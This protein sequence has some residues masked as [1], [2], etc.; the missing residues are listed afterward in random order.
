MSHAP[1]TTVRITDIYSNAEIMDE[2]EMLFT[3]LDGRGWEGHDFVVRTVPPSEMRHMVGSDFET[4]ILQLFEEN[5]S[6][7]SRSLVR[8]NVGDF[9]ETRILVADRQMLVDGYHHFVAALELERSVR[10]ID[11][12]DL[13]GPDLSPDA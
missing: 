8:E 4:P 2:T 9:D 3:A 13:D 1:R 10:L 6:E 12:N 11:L 5:A 7:E